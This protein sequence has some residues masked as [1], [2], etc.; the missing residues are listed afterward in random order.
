MALRQALRSLGVE[1]EGIPPGLEERMDLF[2][3]LVADRRLLIVLDHV[4]TAAQ[5]APLLTSAPEVF[6]II[7]AHRRLPHADA[8]P[9]EVVPLPESYAVELL[10]EVAGKR[11]VKEARARSILPQVLAQCGGSPYALR[12]FA[13]LLEAR[14]GEEGTSAMPGNEPAYAAAQEQ[15]RTLG[16]TA[17]RLYRLS[18]LWPWPALSPAMAGTMAEVGE[19][20]A[21]PLLAELVENLMCG[22]SGPHRQT[23]CQTRGV[24]AQGQ[25]GVQRRGVHGR[26]G[27]LR[28]RVETQERSVP[29]PHH[30][31]AGGGDVRGECA[32]RVAFQ[33]LRSPVLGRAEPRVVGT[34]SGCDSTSTSA[35][36]VPS[37]NNHSGES[38]KTGP[39]SGLR[40][41]DLRSVLLYPTPCETMIN[42]P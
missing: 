40:S 35:T 6:T 5:A 37:A 14:L 13:S 15:Y 3:R 12:T 20:E 21:A 10:T 42:S 7:V 30:T 36:G 16:P 17:A 24:L 27:C 4:Q 1:S 39:V 18:A 26:V 33:H 11:T 9:I 22:L 29:G 25:P 31:T 38:P 2:R 32:A 19:A 23:A 41:P 8:E 34:C 28:V